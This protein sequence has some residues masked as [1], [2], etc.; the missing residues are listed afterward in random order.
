MEGR[1][2]VRYWRRKKLLAI[3]SR[4]KPQGVPAKIE[5]ATNPLQ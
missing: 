4:A 5:T 2:R 3:S 1:L